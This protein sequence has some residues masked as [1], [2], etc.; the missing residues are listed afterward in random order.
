[1][2]GDAPD[3][4]LAQPMRIDSLVVH[5][6]GSICLGEW[7]IMQ[8]W[9]AGLPVQSLRVDSAEFRPYQVTAALGIDSN[10]VAIQF[11]NDAYRPDLGQD[12]NLYVDRIDVNGRSF[13]AR[14]PGVV[15]DFGSGAAA[16]DG[17]NT[18]SSWG[19]MSSNSALH[20]DL[21]GADLLDGGSGVDRMEGGRGN[22]TYL[23]D[24]RLDAVIEI[25]AGGHDIVRANTSFTLSSFVEDLELTGL[26]AIDGTGNTLRNTLRGNGAANRLDGGAGAD[27]LVGGGGNDTYVMARGNGSDTI[28][29]N[30]A[31]PGN[32]DVAE[33]IGDI[34]AD[35]LW[36]RRLGSSLEVSVIGTADRFTVSGW[37]NGNASRVEQFR[38]SDGATLLDR[39]VQA[40]VDAMAA[41]A[42]PPI[43]QTHLSDSLAIPLGPVMAA[44]WQ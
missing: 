31:T 9:I 36:F 43:G 38:A 22:D 44:S 37:Y 8:V 4:A 5:A 27:M 19:A 26:A 10:S 20:F 3:D 14:E 18:A 7:P 15:L 23:V 24:N 32:T 25:E 17:Y 13:G 6:R 29:E 34:G 33:F 39:H 30:D 2:W 11:T 40:L 16:F 12:R 28:Y 1:L 41:F 42:P 21:D 35:Q